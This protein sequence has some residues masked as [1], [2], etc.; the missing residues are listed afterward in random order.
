M[1]SEVTINDYTSSLTHYYQVRKQNI[2]K[3]HITRIKNYLVQ[4][5][6]LIITR[7]KIKKL[8]N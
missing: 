1:R 2:H 3:K 4:G 7:I 8:V 5:L 6:K